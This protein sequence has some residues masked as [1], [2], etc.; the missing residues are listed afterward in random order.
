MLITRETH[1][2]AFKRDESQYL[3]ER[4]KRILALKFNDEFTF[5]YTGPRDWNLNRYRVL[6]HG[7]VE[8]ISVHKHRESTPYPAGPQPVDADDRNRFTSL[9]KIAKDSVGGFTVFKEL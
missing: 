2:E 7:V 1:P 8:L 3:T 4:Q 5:S 6:N 9:E